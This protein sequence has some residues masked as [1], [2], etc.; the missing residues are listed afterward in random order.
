MTSSER[1]I[2]KKQGGSGNVRKIFRN[3]LNKG[4][5]RGAAA[6]RG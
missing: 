6:V 1:A 4:E 2:L 5:H 3:R